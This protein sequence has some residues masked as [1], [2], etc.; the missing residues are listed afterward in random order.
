ML[1]GSALI[2]VIPEAIK[3]LINATVDLDNLKKGD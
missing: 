1:V 3:V 2:V